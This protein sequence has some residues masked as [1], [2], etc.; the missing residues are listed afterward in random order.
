[1]LNANVQQTVFSGPL[2]LSVR[3]LENA[4]YFLCTLMA[5]SLVW[6]KVFPFFKAV[7]YRYWFVLGG[8]PQPCLDPPTS[9]WHAGQRRP[10]C[11]KSVLAQRA[12]A[13]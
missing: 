4:D 13:R 8:N 9:E 12:C 3:L 7:F 2:N 11:W 1:M 5:A 6:K 10:L